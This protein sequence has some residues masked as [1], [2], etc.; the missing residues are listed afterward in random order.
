VRAD[1]AVAADAERMVAETL[2]LFGTLDVSCA[3]AGIFPRAELR[4]LPSAQ[5][6]QDPPGRSRTVSQGRSFVSDSR[7]ARPHPRAPED[8]PLLDAT[9]AGEALLHH[10]P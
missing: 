6:E 3:N 2:K 10:I 4:D 8:R 9:A 7:R 5:R 1:S